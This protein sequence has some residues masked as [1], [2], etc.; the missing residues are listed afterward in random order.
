[1]NPIFQVVF[2]LGMAIWCATDYKKVKALPSSRMLFWAIQMLS[3]AL[4]VAISLN[5]RPRLPSEW[6]DDTVSSWAKSIIGGIMYVQ[7]GD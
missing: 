3:L 1:M 2:L 5:Y 4:F 7:T 6:L